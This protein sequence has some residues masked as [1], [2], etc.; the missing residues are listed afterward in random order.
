MKEFA[1]K[2]VY[3]LFIIPLVFI[4]ALSAASNEKAEMK[5][6]PEYLIGSGDKLEI[7]VW[8]DDSLTRIVT[9]RPDG[10]ISFP[11][12][13]QVKVSGKTV[14]QVKEGL[15]AK[16]KRFIPETELNV[17]V[18]EINSMK[19]YIIGKVNKPGYFVLSEN[20]DVLQALAI[21]GGINTFAKKNKIKIFR[22]TMNKTDIILFKYSDVTNGENLEMNIQLKPGDVVFVP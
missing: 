3:C 2:I 4:F 21:A 10:K 1:V 12:I 20:I 18:R 6:L 22:K 11:L 14:A 13:G 15:E 17:D 9:V 19:I 8:K 5:H 7:S 16:I